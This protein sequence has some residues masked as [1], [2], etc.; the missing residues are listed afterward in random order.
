MN[1][2]E[3]EIPDNLSKYTVPDIGEQENEPVADTL[4]LTRIDIPLPVQGYLA[5]QISRTDPD[6]GPTKTDL[7]RRS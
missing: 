2:P 3:F 5:A 6:E 4:E 1:L 7:S